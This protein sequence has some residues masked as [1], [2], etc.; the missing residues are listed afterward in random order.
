[1]IKDR[2][3]P[4]FIAKFM[5]KRHSPKRLKKEINLIKSG[6]V[7]KG[8]NVLDIGCG[9]GH[10]SLIMAIETGRFGVV[11][12]LDIHP[13]AIKSVEE[14]M[15]INDIKNIRTVLT[16]TLDTELLDNSVDVIFVLNTYDMI[17]DKNKLHNEIDRV[18]K[19]NGK[20]LIRNNKRLLTSDSKY[21]KIFD[22]YDNMTFDYKD[23]KTYYYK[24]IN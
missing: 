10:L 16:R 18:L 21:K 14:L 2:P 22:S 8:D 6:L 19:K 5:Y 12:A 24:K 7:S 3:V 11:T 4:N 23:K 1:M 15:T 20:L 9:P 13:L 17:R